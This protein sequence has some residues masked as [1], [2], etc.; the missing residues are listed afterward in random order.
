MP[1]EDVLMTLSGTDIFGN[2]I[3]ATTLTDADG[4][5]FFSNLVP[6]VYSVQATDPGNVAIY[7]LDG[8]TGSSRNIANFVLSGATAKLD[9]DF[10]YSTIP[11][12]T[13]SIGDLVWT[14]I[15][16]DGVYGTGDTVLS[17]VTITL[18]GKDALGSNITLT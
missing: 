1:I 18:A 17:G 5:Y 8:H 6:G 12:I 11:D 2:T 16:G 4:L 13:G 9:V 10:V 3:L 7:D 15:D 14:D